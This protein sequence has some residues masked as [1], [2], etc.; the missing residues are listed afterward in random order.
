MT[1]TRLLAAGL[2]AVALLPAAAWGQADFFQEGNRLYR[3]GD[4]RAALES[5]VLIE[6]SGFESGPLFY[7]MGNAY[8]KLGHLGAAI[9]YYERA[10]QLLP[11]DDDVRANLELARSLTVDQVTPLPGFLPFRILRWWVDLLSPS[12]LAWLVG[13]AWVLALGAL[14]VRVLR[15]DGPL[16]RWSLRV[17]WLAGVVTVVFGLNLVIREAGLGV[18]DRAVVMAESVDVQSAPSDDPSLQVF[19]V[20]EGTTVRI[21]RRSDDWLEVVLS[22]GQVGWLRAG[23]V[24]EF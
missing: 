16:G 10:I 7:N 9:L 14:S 11:G 21:D 13:S 22:D 17:A 19:T 8:F 15:P 4:F 24:E 1:R 23:A 3:E 20:H 6:E 12:A 2:V 18:P 5:Y